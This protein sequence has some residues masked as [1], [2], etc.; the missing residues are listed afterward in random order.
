MEKSEFACQQCFGQ[1]TAFLADHSDSRARKRWDEYEE[2]CDGVNRLGWTIRNMRNR[3]LRCGNEMV[4]MHSGYR[5][6]F[7]QDKP[8]S[9]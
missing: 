6:F 2:M 9:K 1:M 7:F 8:A 4:K 5:S 3:C